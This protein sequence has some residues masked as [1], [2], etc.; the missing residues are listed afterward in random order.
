MPFDFFGV[1]LGVPQII[2]LICI[3]YG[4]VV[5]LLKNPYSPAV[6][7]ATG[8]NLGLLYWGGFFG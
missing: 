8:L 7:I 6:L 2:M 5:G 3:G 4:V 1:T